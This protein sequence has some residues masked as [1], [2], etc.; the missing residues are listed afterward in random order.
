[1]SSILNIRDYLSNEIATFTIKNSLRDKTLVSFDTYFK[2]NI[3]LELS[4]VNQETP[5]KNLNQDIFLLAVKTVML[6]KVMDL[7]QDLLVLQCL[8]MR[9]LNT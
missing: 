8:K 4:N 6:I 2:E 1:M 5:K 7:L 9:E 3:Q